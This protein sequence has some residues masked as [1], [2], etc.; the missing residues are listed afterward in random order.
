[1][2]GGDTGE[3]TTPPGPRAVGVQTQGCR[4]KYFKIIVEFRFKS[5]RPLS[6][7]HIERRLFEGGP[8][9]KVII[10][11]CRSVEGSHQKEAAI[12]RRCPA[13]WWFLK[14]TAAKSPPNATRTRLPTLHYMYRH[15]ELRPRTTINIHLYLLFIRL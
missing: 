15:T 10:V 12:I 11:K 5:R 1:M 13:G 9:K 14:T 6:E 2:F 3:L 7:V 4:M 8:H